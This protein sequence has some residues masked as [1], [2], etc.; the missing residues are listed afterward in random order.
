MKIRVLEILA[1]LKR[2]GAERMVVSLAGSLDRQ[3]FDAQVVSLY[4][5]FPGG[6]EPVLQELGVP[7]HHL[8]KRRGLD[9]CMYSRLA[10]T[11]RTLRPHII[12]THS[13][14]LRYTFPV[15]MLVPVK[16]MV[17][18]V[19][20]LALQETDAVGRAIHKVA[21]RCGVKSVA[22]GEQV[23]RSFHDYYGFAPTATI[24]NGVD[25]SAFRQPG[26]RTEWRTANGFSP[27]DG[28]IVSVARLDPQKNPLGM[29]DA[30]TKA[31]GTS[32]NWHLLLAGQGSLHGDLERHIAAHNLR[33]RVHLLGS[34]DDVPAI[35]GASDLFLMASDWEGTPMA[36]I[37][38]MAAGLPV[39]STAVGGLS[40]LVVSDSCGLLTPKG[41]MDALAKSLAKLAH[42]DVLRA[43]FS[44]AAR[45]RAEAF[46]L[47]PM[48]DAYSALFER[49][50][51]QM[52]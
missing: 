23:A 8:G 27:T 35:L 13:Y 9:L 20:N 26:N 18:T 45:Q 2:A 30:F 36:V 47:G 4:D 7:T 17:H 42:D 51:E 29:V 52:A 41:D 1:T 48:V 24:A 10:H 25:L 11:I 32:E 38:A 28:L 3:R 14:V 40:E 46:G 21:Y 33:H 19:H 34:R 22:V 49:L 50:M 15:G 5:A 6:F 39:V 37:E 12:H 16:A 43:R 44:A 31:L